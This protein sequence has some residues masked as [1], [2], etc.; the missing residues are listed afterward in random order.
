MIIRELKDSVLQVATEG[1][2]VDQNYNYSAKEELELI[3][4]DSKF[5]YIKINL[6]LN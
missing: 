2:I 6:I 4:E 3:L 1:K 5:L